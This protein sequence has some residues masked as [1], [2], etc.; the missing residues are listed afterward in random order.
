LGWPRDRWSCR[1]LDRPIQCCPR[2]SPHRA[3]ARPRRARR[4]AD[5]LCPCANGI[6]ANR[7]VLSQKTAPWG[8]L[9]S[10]TYPEGPKAAHGLRRPPSA[11][12]SAQASVGPPNPIE[13]RWLAV[14]RPVG[15]TQP[16]PVCGYREAAAQP[17]RTAPR[18]RPSMAGR[19]S[20]S[21]PPSPGHPS[22]AATSPSTCWTAARC[23]PGWEDERV[24]AALGLLSAQDRDGLLAERHPVPLRPLHPLGDADH[25]ADFAKA[26]HG[27]FLA[28]VASSWAC[29]T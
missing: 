18:C 7:P 5:R 22:C 27:R 29:S 2:A 3:A 9:G 20:E 4:R 10:P 11:T 25:A 1:R 21:H 6:P 17:V 13:G 19:M 28:R 15:S 16:S 26:V 14:G 23:G 8:W 12:P 24:L